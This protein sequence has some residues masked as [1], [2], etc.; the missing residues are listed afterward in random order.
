LL[1][2]VEVHAISTATN[3]AHALRSLRSGRAIIPTKSLQMI[4]VSAVPVKHG[5]IAYVYINFP[6]GPPAIAW[7]TYNAQ[8][9]A[10]GGK[11]LAIGQKTIHK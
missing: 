2:A 11:T 8:N 7:S 4:S 9:A 3:S 10:V 1:V 6:M 5:V